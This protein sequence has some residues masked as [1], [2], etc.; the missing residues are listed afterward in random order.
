VAA[1]GGR[2]GGSYEFR[3][4]VLGRVISRVA[5]CSFV[6]WRLVC[7]AYLRCGRYLGVLER[8]P[9]FRASIRGNGQRLVVRRRANVQFGAGGWGP[10]SACM[11]GPDKDD[12]HL[13]DCAIRSGSSREAEE[14]PGRLG[15]V[16][17]VVWC[18]GRWCWGVGWWS[19]SAGRVGGS[20]AGEAVEQRA[21]Y[22]LTQRCSREAIAMQA[23]VIAEVPQRAK[24]MAREIVFMTSGAGGRALDAGGAGWVERRASFKCTMWGGNAGRMCRLLA[25]GRSLG[26]RAAGTTRRTNIFCGLLCSWAE[27]FEA[28]SNGKGGIGPQCFR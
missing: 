3:G 21:L 12:R 6:S 22:V 11:V 1:F 20:A 19:G 18:G 17:V 2:V 16:S 24:S 26:Q 8:G 7:R 27:G 25:G 23:G 5:N 13:H 9:R 10:G 4:L 28:R 14:T 15:W